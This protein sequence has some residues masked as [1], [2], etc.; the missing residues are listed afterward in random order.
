MQLNYLTVTCGQ[1]SNLEICN[2]KMKKYFFTLPISEFTGHSCSGSVNSFFY[3]NVFLMKIN[4]CLL[5]R[6]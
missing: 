3:K 5:I 2:K 1:Q 4:H 6:K